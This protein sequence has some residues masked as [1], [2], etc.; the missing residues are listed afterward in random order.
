MVTRQE[1]SAPGSA[2]RRGSCGLLGA[3]ESAASGIFIRGGSKLILYLCSQQHIENN[4]V[5]YSYASYCI[6][7]RRFIRGSLSAQVGRARGVGR[8]H[9]LTWLFTGDSHPSLLLLK[10]SPRDP[11]SAPFCLLNISC[12][13]VQACRRVLGFHGYADVITDP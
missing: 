8:W 10:R 6:T 7:G 1:Q 12:F 5:W 11:S 9:L 3:D 4:C 13:L 2:A